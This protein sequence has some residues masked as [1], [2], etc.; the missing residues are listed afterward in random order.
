[1]LKYCAVGIYNVLQCGTSAS[2]RKIE[3]TNMKVFT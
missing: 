2:G 3:L 1:M